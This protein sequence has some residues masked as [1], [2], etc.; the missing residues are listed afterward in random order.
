MN[1]L[2]GKIALFAGPARK[3]SMG[4]AIAVKPANGVDNPVVV[5]KY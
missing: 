5:D 1:G 3:R 2:K 4:H